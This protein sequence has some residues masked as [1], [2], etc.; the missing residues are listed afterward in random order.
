MLPLVLGF[1]NGFFR[2]PE[3]LVEKL[4]RFFKS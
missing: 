4:Q 1:K 3:L 2:E